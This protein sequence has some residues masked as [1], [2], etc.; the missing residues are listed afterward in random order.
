[1][2]SSWKQLVDAG[3]DRLEAEIRSSGYLVGSSFSVADL[4]AAALLSILVLPEQHLHPPTS[5]APPEVRALLDRFGARLGTEWVRE[6]YRRRRGRSA[7][8]SE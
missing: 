6:M 4:T 1:M 7:A 5:E 3:F 2:A 8:V